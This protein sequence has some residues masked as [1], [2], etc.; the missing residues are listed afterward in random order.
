[1]FY[2]VKVKDYVRVAPDK[3]KDNLEEALITELKS[4]YDG[5][6]S[7]ELG[8]VIDVAGIDVMR[9]GVIIPGD[10]AVFYATEFSLITFIPEMQEVILGRIKDIADFGAFINIGPAEGM[11]HISQTMNDFVSFNKEKTLIGKDTKRLLKVGDACR[12]RIVSISFKDVSNPKIGLTMRQ[13][14]L[15]KE[16][17]STEPI[18][19]KAKKGKEGKDE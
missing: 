16:E 7:T 6:I 11:I 12:A 18:A 1:M 15:G 13:D 3:F 2:K 17:W 10:G 8:T 9:D 19:V 5:H 14:G 4:K